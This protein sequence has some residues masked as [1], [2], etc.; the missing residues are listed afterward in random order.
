MVQ[1]SAFFAKMIAYITVVFLLIGTFL[2]AGK[3]ELPELPETADASFAEE[4]YPDRYKKTISSPAV[5]NLARLLDADASFPIPGIPYAA[6]ETD[7]GA[8]SLCDSM[9][10]QGV[11]FAGE[12]GEYLLISAYCNDEALENSVY[13]KDITEEK[14]ESVIYI[15]DASDGSLLSTATVDSYSDTAK[16]NKT[17]A[18]P[19]AGGIAYL[20]GR[21]WIAKTNGIL[22]V[23]LSQI[24]ALVQSGAKTGRLR[25]AAAKETFFG[26]DGEEIAEY[27]SGEAISAFRLD[28]RASF[29]S[30]YNGLLLV[31][32]YQTED[33]AALAA[34]EIA[35]ADGGITMAEQFRAEIPL[36]AQGAYI[37][38]RDGE[39]YLFV[40]CSN[41]A[42]WT[43]ELSVYRLS[44][45]GAN[46]EK[47]ALAAKIPVPNLC[48][49]L[50]VKDGKLYI[51]YES[52]AN[53]YYAWPEAADRSLLPCDRVTAI[54][55]DGLLG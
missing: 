10:P 12:N 50:D 5:R 24:E 52:A 13:H 27:C 18:P 33:T 21:L 36:H 42:R 14:H 26:T 9:T 6:V 11:C 55:I 4:A 30:T 43:G 54:D 29:M 31:G 16:A 8:I 20:D 1:I 51:C 53:V 48:E 49:D 28:T 15:L 37:L 38:D 32:E 40:T 23:E 39:P 17:G 35:F 2:G 7:G 3:V 34:Y 19:H 44:V 22:A 46:A 47:T 45:D 41:G 25:C